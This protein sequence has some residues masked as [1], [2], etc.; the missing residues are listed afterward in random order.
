MYLVSS[1]VLYSWGSVFASA[2]G[3]KGCFPPVLC[4]STQVPS[5]PVFRNVAFKYLKIKGVFVDLAY[6]IPVIKFLQRTRQGLRCLTH[7]Q[8][9]GRAQ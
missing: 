8:K 4:W 1:C 5:K 3:S 2:Q 6:Y 9:K 7:T